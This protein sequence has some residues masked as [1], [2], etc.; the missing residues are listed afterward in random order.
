[1]PHNASYL[2]T[3]GQN[4]ISEWLDKNWKFTDRDIRRLAA[5]TVPDPETGEPVHIFKPEFLAMLKN[6]KSEISM[7]MMPEGELAFA[8]EPIYKVSGPIWQC[9][10]VESA[11]LNTMNSQSNFATYASILK[12]AAN[13]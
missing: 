4:I 2:V 5:K 6:A 7:D 1:T 12:T 11:I 8:S 9:L 10:A 13:G 3:A